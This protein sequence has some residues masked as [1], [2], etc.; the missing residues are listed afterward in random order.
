MPIQL[1]FNIRCAVD[2]IYIFDF[3][4]AMES[5]ENEGLLTNTT[6]RT[7][8]KSFGNASSKQFL[9]FQI[10]QRK[11][12]FL[13]LMASPFMIILLVLNGSSGLTFL[14]QGQVWFKNFVDKFKQNDFKP[15]SR[16]RLNVNFGSRQKIQ[17]TAKKICSRLDNVYNMSTIG[18]FI[19]IHG[20]Q[21]TIQTRTLDKFFS[22][23][24]VRGPP[25][26]L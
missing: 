12:I 4:N 5:L 24:E 13:V 3:Q 15:F 25:F 22:R 2:M 21:R 26:H 9:P 8:N 14:H 1:N 23:Q 17:K 11:N 20:P 7:N 10:C 19:K 16:E 6:K 18:T